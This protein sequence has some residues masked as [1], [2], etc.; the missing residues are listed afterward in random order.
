LKAKDRVQQQ[1][2]E[3]AKTHERCGVLLPGHLS[4]GIHTG[5]PIEPAFE[6]T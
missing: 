1:G 4:V 3:E 2:T 5:Q 6:R